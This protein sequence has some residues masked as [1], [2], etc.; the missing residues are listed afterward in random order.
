LRTHIRLAAF[1]ALALGTVALPAAALAAGSTTTDTASD[2]TVRLT[3]PYPALS[4]EPGSIVK[5]D[6]TAHA[7]EPERVDLSLG[8]VPQGWKAT[9]RGGG[10]VIAGLT[11]GPATPGTA[12][13]EIDVA[14][15]AAPKDY[16]VTVTEKAADGTST[17]NIT[18]TVAPVVDNGIGVKADFPSLKG[19]PTDTFNYTLTLTNNTPVEQAFNFAGSGADGWTV[20]VSPQAEAKA[21]TVSIAAGSNATVKVAATPPSGVAEGTYPITIDVT[22]EAGGHGTIQ[23]TAEVAGTGKL[24][25]ATADERLNLTGHSNSTTKE[26]LIVA[27]AGTAPLE[28]VTFASTPPAGW[29]V[30]FEPTSLQNVAPGETQQ[31]V[32]VIKPAKGALAGDYAIATTA[33]AGADHSTLNLRFGVTTS[34]SWT[35][36]GIIVALAGVGILFFGYRRLG[37]R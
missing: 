17:L 4:V 2:P 21:N 10:F 32:A 15:D 6:L 12:Q 30:T 24:Q 8:G 1:A 9:L 36:F 23:L 22:G 25:V 3:T 13:L 18:I 5:L 19:G 14:P 11:A 26:T 28:K 35:V 31:V 27:N 20:D 37:R 7:P 34:R 29:T 16:P 33:S